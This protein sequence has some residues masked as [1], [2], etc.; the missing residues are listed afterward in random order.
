MADVSTT[1]ERYKELE[2]IRALPR[3]LMSGTKAMREAGEKFTPKHPAEER[4]SYNVRI[5]STTLF[6]AFSDTVKKQAGKM[7]A[8]QII[9]NED[10]PDEI[11]PILS[12]IDG[13]GRNF[14]TFFYDAFKDAM[15]DGISFIYVDFPVIKKEN[16]EFVTKLDLNLQG[17]RPN[18]I[19]INACNL[20]SAKGANVNGNHFLTEARIRE[21][22]ITEKD[23][24]TNKEI[25]Q[26]R[27]LKIGSWEIWRNSSETKA[28]TGWTLYDEGNSGLNYIPL[29][30]VYTN[31]VG[32]FEGEPP[33]LPLAELNLA[34]WLSSSEQARALTMARFDML[35]M[36]GVEESDKINKVAPNVILKASNPQAKCNNIGTSGA[37]IEQGRLDI[38]GIEKR[39]ETAGMTVRVES[40]TGSTATAAKINSEDSDNALMALAESN[41]VTGNRIMQIFGD[42]LNINA[43]TININVKSGQRKPDGS[44]EDIAKIYLAGLISKEL[45]LNELIRRNFLDEELDI[46]EEIGRSFEQSID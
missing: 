6:N 30:P 13:Q 17:A 12:N 26:I 35:F 19:L 3:A 40:A 44:N 29:V 10:V 8:S 28:V 18:T 38:E 11:K 5:L 27:V 32:F 25:E 37:G 24:Y 22:V 15:V 9:L 2:E 7:F 20:I 36:A 39:M 14:T 21:S 34:H 1:S 43:G 42:Y 46:E 23:E 33:L 31:R 45:A 16:S 4:S 41:E